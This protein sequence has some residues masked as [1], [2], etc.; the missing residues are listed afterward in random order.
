MLN[1][2]QPTQSCSALV[3]LAQPCSIL[4]N[5][6]QP[7]F[8]YFLGVYGGKYGANYRLYKFQGDRFDPCNSNMIK[9]LPNMQFELHDG[10]GGTCP[11]SEDLII[12]VRGMKSR[13]NGNFKR[14]VTY[15]VSLHPAL[16]WL[17]KV[18]LGNIHI[19]CQHVFGLFEPQ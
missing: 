3:Y 7:F 16:Q 6:A 11:L 17:T 12:S 4:L 5:L 13:R 19:L 14:Y 10:N 2:A 8:F 9:K 18:A 15:Y 1:L